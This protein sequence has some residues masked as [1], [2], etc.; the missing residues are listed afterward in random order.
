MVPDVPPTAVI[1]ELVKHGAPVSEKNALGW[2]S[3][4]EAVSFG[5]RHTSEFNYTSFHTHLI[6]LYNVFIK[7]HFTLLNLYCYFV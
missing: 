3:L 4:Q 2:S 6:S 5:D 1:E 7:I